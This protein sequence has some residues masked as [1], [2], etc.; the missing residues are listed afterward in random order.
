MKQ[1]RLFFLMFAD[2]NFIF[3]LV[4]TVFLTSCDG[5]SNAEVVDTPYFIENNPA[6]GNPFEGKWRR[7]KTE[8]SNE[9][10]NYED[11]KY[12]HVFASDGLY[13]TEGYTKDISEADKC[14][15][16]FDSQYLILY[17]SPDIIDTFKYK[18][19]ESNVLEFSLYNAN[20]NLGV[21]FRQSVETLRKE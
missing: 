6:E 11:K 1:K 5:D 16:S 13:S 19:V 17:H 10:V 12:Y 8:Y 4:C 14:T 20:H 3:Y 9:T 21:A 18:F 7:V 15:Y 2:A